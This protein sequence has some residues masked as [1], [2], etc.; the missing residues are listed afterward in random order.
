MG[1][2]SGHDAAGAGRRLRSGMGSRA[3]L[4]PTT[5]R[6]WSRSGRAH[7][8]LRPHSWFGRGHGQL[9]LRSLLG[10]A[11]V[12]AASGRG[13][14]SGVGSRAALAPR[15]PG[16]GCGQ[17]VLMDNS[18]PIRGRARSWATP[19]PLGAW[20][21]FCGSGLWPRCG[22]CRPRASFGGGVASCARSYDPPALVAVRACSWTTPTPFVVRA[23]SWATPAPLVALGSLCGS[24]L[25]P[26]CGLCRPR[27]SFGDGI[28]SCARSY[29]PPALVAVRACSW[30][31]PT[32]FV[33]G[34]D[35]GQ[36]PL[37]SV[38]GR[39]FVGVASGR[40]ART[41]GC[42][43]KRP[44]Q[45]GASGRQVPGAHGPEARVCARVT[46]VRT[47]S[48]RHPA[49]CIEPVRRSHP[50]RP[51]RR[52]SFPDRLPDRYRPSHRCPTGCRC[53]ACP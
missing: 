18:D 11:F 21:S 51:G 42:K 2:A 6:L 38:L 9:P 25:W 33:V 12:G 28:V 20:A 22:V 29:D 49:R 40:D 10:R 3:A 26:R 13:L 27:A 45:G 30:T 43:R 17:G 34:R 5:P 19:A 7:G 52:C 15:T 50:R 44:A 39:A 16:S 1:A 32:P 35:H 24:G 47:R 48:S 4:A 41:G 36:L 31:T 14:R 53:T 8:Q 37:R 23:R 46:A